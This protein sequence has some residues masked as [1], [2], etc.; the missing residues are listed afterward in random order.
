MPMA[1]LQETHP[2]IL[3]VEDE[4]FMRSMIRQM[5]AQIGITDFYEAGNAQAGLD[6]TLRIRPDAVLCD[7]FLPGEDGFAYLSWIRKSPIPEVAAIPVI[8]LTAEKSQKA[9]LMAK[10]LRANGYLVKPISAIGVQRALSR[11]LA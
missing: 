9:V 1:D 5:L 4:R 7:V 11:A 2:R 6:E 8:M 10:E 3:I